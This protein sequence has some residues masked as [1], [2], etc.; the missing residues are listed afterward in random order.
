MADSKSRAGFLGAGATGLKGAALAADAPDGTVTEG[1]FDARFDGDT[2]FFQLDG[3]SAGQV[4]GPQGGEAYA[5]VV[6]EKLGPD[7][8]AKKHIGNV[9]YNEF[10][11]QLGMGMTK[12]LYEWVKN[13]WDGNYTRK[14]GAVV[15][16]DFNYKEKARA[17]FQDALITEFTVPACDATSK[18]PAYM[19]L[20]AAPGA[21]R[22]Q[23]PDGTPVGQPGTPLPLNFKV[24]IEGVDATRVSK[25]ESFTV[26]Q[27]FTADATGQL[28]PTHLEIP[29]LAIWLDPADSASWSA[30]EDDFVLKGNSGD[31]KERSGS[32][33]Y[34]NPK[35]VEIL[36][37]SF[38]NLGIFKGTP[39][40]SENNSDKIRRVKYE[41]YCESITM[42]IGDTG[43]A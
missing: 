24:E 39:E 18:D 2:F 21:T 22:Y 42:K 5:D 9:K 23:D 35:E 40:A 37:L 26:K 17:T 27:G 13:S 15:A 43:W 10:S 7:H 31:D 6:T 16:A 38:S 11:V 29:N 3:A 4:F 12:G 14:N 20:K 32:L 8:I 25:I 1:A 28:E 34:F 36:R 30:W 33:I 19:V 41:L